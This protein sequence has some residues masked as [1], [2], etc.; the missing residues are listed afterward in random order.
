VRVFREDVRV[1]L[2]T[3][4]CDIMTYI[5]R[6]NAQ[7]STA[8]PPKVRIIQS[9][10]QIPV[11]GPSYHREK[12]GGKSALE[13]ER[14]F[15]RTVAFRHPGDSCAPSPS[16]QTF[17]NIG[18]RST[19]TTLSGPTRCAGSGSAAG[20]VVNGSSATNMRSSLCYPPRPRERARCAGVPT[21]A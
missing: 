15:M 1:K 7:Q 19:S 20:G 6:L 21:R 18:D 11:T 5:R 10:P 16:A 14:T 4:F 9:C 12:R 2:S 3:V 13:G 17:S 8:S